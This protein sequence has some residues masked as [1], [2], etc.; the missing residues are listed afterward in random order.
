MAEL[1]SIAHFLSQSIEASNSKNA[2]AHLKSLETQPGF[3]VTLMHVIASSNLPVAT[4]LAG[5]LFFKNF[6]KRKWINENGVYMI[7]ESLSLI[8]I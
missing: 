3:A 1:G 4:R 2:E 5:A 8:H 7:A 6:I